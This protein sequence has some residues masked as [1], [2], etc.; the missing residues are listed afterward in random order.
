M[1]A[2][3]AEVTRTSI[4]AATAT[5]EARRYRPTAVA[6]PPDFAAAPYL[7]VGTV[8]GQVLRVRGDSAP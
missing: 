7:F 3:T 2:I 1:R 6:L 5:N 4:W 8:D